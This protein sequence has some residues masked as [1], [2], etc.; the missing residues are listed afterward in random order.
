MCLKTCTEECRVRWCNAREPRVQMAHCVLKQCTGATCAH[1]NDTGVDLHQSSCGNSEISFSTKAKRRLYVSTPDK[2]TN[3]SQVVLQRM[4]RASSI[5]KDFMVPV[6]VSS[7]QPNNSSSER[8]PVR[9]H[10]ASPWFPFLP[11]HRFGLGERSGI[12]CGCDV[13]PH[14][15]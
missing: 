1:R 8:F 7:V 11:L 13:W 5:P 6:P 9:S 15:G 12:H 4:S 10:F 3:L 14:P 2:V